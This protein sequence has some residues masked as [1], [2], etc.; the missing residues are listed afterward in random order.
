[1]AEENNG[2]LHIRLHVYDEEIDVNIDRSEE[3]YYRDAAKMITERYNKY[4]PMY[5]MHMSDHKIALMVLID[6]ALRYQKEAV[7]N[8]TTPYDD[9]LKGLTDEIEDAL[10]EKK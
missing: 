5:K 2:K 10:G 9:I 6:I 8:D 3:Q 1:M 7:R 4:A